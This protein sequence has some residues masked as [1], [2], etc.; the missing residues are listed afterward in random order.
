MNGRELEIGKAGEHLAAAD[1]ILRGFHACLADQ[2][3]PF[4]LIVDAGNRLLKIQVKTTQGPIPP[5]T[6]KWRWP[7]YRFGLRHGKGTRRRIEAID[8][9]AFVTLDTKTVC[10]VSG[11][12][13]NTSVGIVGLIE[14]AAPGDESRSNWRKRKAGD[15][16]VFPPVPRGDVTP[17]CHPK[18]KHYAGGYCQQC[19]CRAR[20]LSQ[21]GMKT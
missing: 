10:Y 18:R 1:L 19:Y 7:V 4:D 5:R 17:A 14:F 8:V 20:Y 16:Q 2:G 21:R 15:Y 13:L 11:E 9:F 6:G 12:E 3:S